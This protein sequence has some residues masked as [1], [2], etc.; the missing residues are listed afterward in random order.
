[1]AELDS[2][3]PLDPAELGL[4][5]IAYEKGDGRATIAFDRPE[6]LNAFDFATL[7]ELSRAI[8]DASWDDRVRV[9]VLTGT[10]ERSFCT[11]ADLKEQARIAERPSE[12]WKWMGQFVEAHDRLR[13]CGKPT[14]ARV[15]GLCVGGGNEFHMACDL[16]VACDD[17]IFRHVG[18]QHGSVPAG[19]A[20]QWLPILVGDRRAREMIMLCENVPAATALEWGLVNR[21]VPRDGLDATTDALCATLADLLP[22]ATRYA[23]QQLNWWRDQSWHATIGH[24]RD[25]LTLHA[26]APETREAIHA[27]LEKRPQDRSVTHP[28]PPATPGE[29]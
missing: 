24:A 25:W 7:R 21:V 6:V 26:G 16:S 3:A 10:G 28:A 29:R 20:T 4:R 19:G 1:M 23:K 22:E 18:L 13:N 12:Y 15:N 9:I 27:F 14:V 5:R 11:G 2:Y 17:A 8:E